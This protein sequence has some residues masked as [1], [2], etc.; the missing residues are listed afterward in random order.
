MFERFGFRSPGDTR[1]G[2]RAFT[3]IE[4][5]VVVAVISL[6]ASMLVPV[7]ASVIEEARQ[8]RGQNEL[9]A[10]ATALVKYKADQGHFPC[11]S[12]AGNFSFNATNLNAD[13][14]AGGSPACAP[15]YT[16]RNLIKY[17]DKQIATDPW[18]NNY[19]YDVR[20]VGSEQVVMVRS[21]GQDRTDDTSATGCDLINKAITSCD[22]DII[23]YAQ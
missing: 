20:V 5:I 23:I 16:A 7:V 12:N 17:L 10:L 13:I 1:R 21:I 6:L 18:T 3:L 2:E 14:S 11:G 19:I 8:A 4:I 15:A 22:D 9:K